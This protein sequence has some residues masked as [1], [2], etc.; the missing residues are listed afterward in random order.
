M[1]R[2]RKKLNKQIVYRKIIDEKTER[3]RRIIEATQ[4]KGVKKTKRKKNWYINR[5][6]ERR[7]KKYT[8]SDEKCCPHPLVVIKES[9]YLTLKGN[10]IV[11]SGM[12]RDNVNTRN[13]TDGGLTSFSKLNFGCNL[14][15][16]KEDSSNVTL[17]NITGGF[18]IIICKV[19]ELYSSEK[20][21]LTFIPNNCNCKDF[22][23]L[24]LCTSTFSVSN[25]IQKQL[26][27]HNSIDYK[28]LK[29]L[30]NSTVKRNSSHHYGSS[31]ECFSFGLR[32]S[33]RTS[34]SGNV[35]L[36]RY[37]GDM[38][39]NGYKYE[40]YIWD[41]LYMAFQSFNQIIHG[42]SSKINMTSRSM[43]KLSLNTE[44]EQY[45]KIHSCN[46]KNGSTQYILSGNINVNATTKQLHCEKDT[47]YTT[48]HV[49]I[50]TDTTAYIT[51]QFQLNEQFS[52]NFKCMQNNCFT[53]SAYCLAHRQMYTSGSKSMN[54]ST[55]SGG[56]VY[57]NYRR[58]YR[59][60]NKLK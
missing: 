51:F 55:Y 16:I 30:K 56:R 59:R 58:S 29:K 26:C 39:T 57:C 12:T 44:L 4:L 13:Y 7:L 60:V 3:V 36:T 52:L 11:V 41:S 21:N 14:Q 28:H 2:S 35:T 37:A 15:H 38:D 10:C 45:T 46:T 50:Q 18:I 24:L 33:Y 34:P 6:A 20:D 54:L 19:E 47:T 23:L 40:S 9:T 49:P 1:V 32:N 31:G 48:I 53:Y 8:V 25:G 42:V 27:W 22:A 5:K 43:K 17:N